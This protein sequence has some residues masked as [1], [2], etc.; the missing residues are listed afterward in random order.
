MTQVQLTGDIKAWIQ[1]QGSIQTRD[2]ALSF[3][4]VVPA[5]S[6]LWVQG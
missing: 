3:S 6:R 1:E 4:Q 5:K 2:S